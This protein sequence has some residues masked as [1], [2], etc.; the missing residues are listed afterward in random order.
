MNKTRQTRRVVNVNGRHQI[1]T[2]Q[3]K[4]CKVILGKLLATQM[5][6]NAAQSAKATRGDA[7]ALEVGQLD[8]AVVTDHYILHVSFSVDKNT[9]L[10][11]GLMRKLA[12]LSRKL[13]SYDL[14]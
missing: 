9:N 1:Q 13:W 10:S 14:V 6:M 8:S 7:N 3:G 12:Q 11:S 5:S 2:Q 4:V